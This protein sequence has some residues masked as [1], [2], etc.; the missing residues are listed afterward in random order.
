MCNKES[1]LV[2]Q[3]CV[4]GVL[5]TSSLNYV[6]NKCSTSLHPPSIM[7]VT[8][9]VHLYILPQLCVCATSLHPPSIM[10]VTSAAHLYI[11]PNY[12]CTTSLHLPSIRRIT[13]YIAHH[14][15]A[16]LS[17]ILVCNVEYSQSWEQQQKP[18]Q[19]A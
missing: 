19:S 13:I 6:C 17:N 2:P 5:F 10:C 1:L 14:S 4:A 9:A 11:L 7:C 15:D 16:Y 12:K 8:S 18:H 3:L